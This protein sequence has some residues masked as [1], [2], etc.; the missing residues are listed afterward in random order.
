MTRNPGFRGA[1]W[2]ARSHTADV[3][4]AKPGFKSRWISLQSG[5]THHTVH[6][7]RQKECSEFSKHWVQ[8]PEWRIHSIAQLRDIL[9][10]PQS[11]QRFH[12]TLS[13]S[14]C[15]CRWQRRPSVPQGRVFTHLGKQI[16]DITSMLPLDC[17]L[18]HTARL[19]NWNCKAEVCV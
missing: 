7:L 9:P 1:K 13:H 4:M 16:A 19:A 3:F 17:V 12:S 11:Q 15:H 8:W 6:S 5:F 2:L 14:F 18:M 10:P